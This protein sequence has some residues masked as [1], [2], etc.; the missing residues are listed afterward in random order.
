MLV[1]LT[2]AIRFF[3]ACGQEVFLDKGM[4]VNIVDYEDLIAEWGGYN[5]EIVREEF[6]HEVH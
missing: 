1:T 2:R 3:A 5:F 4:Q 6:E